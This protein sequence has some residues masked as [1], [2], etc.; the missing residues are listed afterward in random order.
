M[1]L[2]KKQPLI[3]DAGFMLAEC[4]KYLAFQKA[5]I[6]TGLI[7]SQ[8]TE[9]SVKKLSKIPLKISM[10]KAST[11]MDMEL[12]RSQRN[13]SPK[14]PNAVWCTDITCIPT[15]KGFVYL[16]CIMDLFFRKIVS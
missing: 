16:S 15:R 1:Q 5:D 6:M 4:W 11:F 7:V 10:R 14:S 13:F 8:V 12:L 3:R 2:L 9:A